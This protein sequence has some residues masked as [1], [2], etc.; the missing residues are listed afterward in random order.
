MKDVDA[1]AYCEATNYINK[2]KSPEWYINWNE[3][4]T[5]N[6]QNIRSITNPTDDQMSDIMEQ[7]KKKLVLFLKQEKSKLK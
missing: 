4:G 3:I 7:F 6:A 2:T 1:K 5:S